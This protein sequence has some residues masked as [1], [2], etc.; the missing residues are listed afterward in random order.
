MQELAIKY[1]KGRRIPLINYCASKLD[2]N[3]LNIN[4]FTC[5]TSEREKFT[6]T[7]LKE[8]YEE[9]E[10]HEDQKD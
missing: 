6:E 7:K 5:E 1:E 10:I 8:Y 3:N 9:S 2:K 4:V